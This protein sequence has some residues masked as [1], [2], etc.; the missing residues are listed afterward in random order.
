MTLMASACGN[1]LFT[2][3]RVDDGGS[4]G[5]AS[6]D[7][8]DVV[9]PQTD[10]HVVDVVTPQTDGHVVDV[11][12]PQ[13]DGP[14]PVF[15]ASIDQQVLPDSA[16]DAIGPGASRT[17]IIDSPGGQVSLGNATLVVP[18]NA[19]A[20][21]TTVTLTLISSDGTLAGYPGAIGP[22]FSVSKTDALGQP[23]TLQKP[24]TFEL[25]FTPA[26]TSIPAARVALA[27]WDTQSNPNLWIA[28]VGSSYD[29]GSGVVTGSVFEFAGTRL[30]APV[31]S[32]L[33]GQTCPDPEACA[34]GACQ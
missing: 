31:E 32:C 22:I 9:P 23:V 12:P 5:R 25:N 34:G 2:L 30:F 18:R 21:P 33:T 10:G 29:P 6:I 27:Y 28:I 11:A 26:D 15:D 3:G 4:D 1:G 20:Q 19:F 17:E 7:A 8:A 16:A 14:V 13:T 24:A